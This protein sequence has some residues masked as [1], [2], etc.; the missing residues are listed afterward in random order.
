MNRLS[1]IDLVFFLTESEESPK[2]VGGISIFKKPPGAKK[3]WVREFYEDL[4]SRD[5]VQSPFNHVINFRAFGGPRWDQAASV[6]IRDHVLY[7]SSKTVMSEE[8]LYDLVAGLHEP[9]LDRKKPLWQFHIIDNVQGNRFAMYTKIHHAYADGVTMSRWLNHS[10]SKSA[11]SRQPT[12]VWEQKDI[13]SGQKERKKQNLALMKALSRGTAQWAQVLGGVSKLVA[14]LA[15]EGVGLTTNA[16]S[17]PFKAKE[18]TPFT[19]H[20]T[21]ERQL[22]SASIDMQRLAKLRSATRCT[23]NHIAL[24]CIDGALRRYLLDNGID[25]E[26]PI[27]IQMPVNLRDRND[28][29]SGNKVGLVLV[30]LAPPTDDPYERLR[31]IGFTLR[32]VRNQIDGVPAIAV[33]QYT[34]VMAVLMELIEVLELNRFLPAVSDTLVSNVP[35][36]AETMYMDGAKL[37]Q[38]L[39]V[40]TLPPGSQ[41]NITL[42]SYDGTL[43][44]GLVATRKVVGLRSLARYIEQAFD[45][46]EESVYNAA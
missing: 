1:L 17:I 38:S 22:A 26:R 7:H 28:R 30:D 14:Q 11:T 32:A 43:Y 21:P 18:E 12:A 5:Q 19:G 16:V 23:L 15:L 44:F 29:I 2:H 3:S 41:M 34:A 45:E 31:E 9:V 40:S 4:L 20:V 25:L 46:L 33:Q 8:K 10:L 27:S 13:G 37:V 36:P 6:D 39:P 24:T 35:G 42:Y